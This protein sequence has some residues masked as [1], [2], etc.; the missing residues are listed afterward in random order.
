MKAVLAVV[1]LL[2]LLPDVLHSQSSDAEL[3]NVKELI[4]DIVLDLKYSTVVNFTAQKLYTTNECL[5]ARGMVNRLAVVQ[6]SLRARG[7][8]L[9]IFDG[10]RPRAVQYL[11][12][13]IYPDPNFVA[14]PVT[15]SKHNRGAAVD[16]TL[17][18]LATGAELSMPTAF[19]YFGDAAAHGWTIGL[20]AE[21]IANRELLRSMMEDV[22]GLTRL[23]SE[24]WHYEHA[25][26]TSIPLYDFQM[27]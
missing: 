7:L 2:F 4:P 11:M 3:V 20:S 12:F 19:D 13:E 24:W 25:P 21:Q 1:C 15:G 27:K 10:Y 9:K 16:L 22:G 17:I 26:S 8:G 5:L 23:P 18:D 6:D 14:D